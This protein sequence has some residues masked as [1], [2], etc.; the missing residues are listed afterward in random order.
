MFW[1]LEN[2]EDE[3]DAR[4]DFA[5][6]IRL[7]ACF[8]TEMIFIVPPQSQSKGFDS[9]TCLIK[10]CPRLPFTIDPFP[11]WLGWGLSW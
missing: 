10:P 9:S 1:E 2:F 7:M 6:N 11:F 3:L 4:S 8:D 5:N